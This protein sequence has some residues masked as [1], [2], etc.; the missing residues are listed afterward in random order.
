MQ[1]RKSPTLLIV[2]VVM[3]LI[4]AVASMALLVP[5]VRDTNTAVVTI[6]YVLALCAPIGLVLAVVFALLSGR[7]SR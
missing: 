7:R 2:A 5:A 3:V 4:G 6:V 1:T